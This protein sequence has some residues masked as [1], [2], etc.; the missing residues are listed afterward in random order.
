MRDHDT[1]RAAFSDLHGRRLHGFALLVS[2]GDAQ[3][4]GR[5][6][7]DAL[8]VGSRHAAALS[9]PERAAAWLRARVL[10]RL[11]HA[12]LARGSPPTAARR[13]EL[14]RLGVDE[15][16]FDGLASLSL[17]GR[18][19]LTATTIERFEP[20]DV[21]TILGTSSS[22][23]RR[24][25]MRA[26]RR[27]LAAVADRPVSSEATPAGGLSRRVNGV[28]ERALASAPARRVL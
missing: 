7:G 2:L 11:R 15:A 24:L 22:A 27:Y 18:A 28:A 10:G 12:S 23:T 26:N 16:T 17:A 20:M 8:A 13:A 25:V 9:H 3:R 19:A 14:A 6:T 1:L 21:E 4:A 5:A